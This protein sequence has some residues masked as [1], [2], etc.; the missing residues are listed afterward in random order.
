[1]E[2]MG[3]TPKKHTESKEDSLIRKLGLAGI[4]GPA[5]FLLCSTIPATLQPGY[6]AIK[7]TISSLVWTPYGWMQTLGFCALGLLLMVFST[8][9]YKGIEKRCGLK[10]GATALFLVGAGVLL[11]GVFPTNPGL[12]P[13]LHGSI[14]H[15]A[16]RLVGILFPIAIFSLVFSMK[17]DRR[18][19]ALAV[20]TV[21]S[22]VFV[23]ALIFVW[24][25]LAVTGLM[26]S[27]VGLY[28]RVFMAIAMT[29]LVAISIRLIMLSYRSGHGNYFPVNTKRTIWGH[30]GEIGR[31][32]YGQMKSRKAAEDQKTRIIQA[33]KYTTY[34]VLLVLAIRQHK[35][36]EKEAKI[37]QSAYTPVISKVLLL[38]AKKI[39][40]RL[41]IAPVTTVVMDII[42]D[43]Q[44]AN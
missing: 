20:Y 37:N 12:D 33:L 30:V 10:A 38:G 8:G 42:I 25:C 4:L 13:T 28:E 1:M 16:A 18:W 11:V 3:L 5:I 40:Q 6:N 26:N 7:N 15:L 43:E 27:W 29:W 35:K 36:N 22:G 2:G 44:K 24:I 9:L 14:H 31:V 19:K 34:G 39:G 17:S 21:V 23:T 41:G 32:I